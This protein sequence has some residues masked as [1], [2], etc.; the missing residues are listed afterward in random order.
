MR[1]DQEVPDVDENGLL[2]G[3]DMLVSS[4]LDQQQPPISGTYFLTSLV[5]RL[6]AESL[7]GPGNEATA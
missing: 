6:S 5:P 1:S 2:L 4:Q 3:I 7:A